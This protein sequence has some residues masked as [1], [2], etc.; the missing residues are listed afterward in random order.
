MADKVRAGKVAEDVLERIRL[1]KRRQYMKLLEV[2]DLTKEL[3]QAAERRD[4][5]AVKMLLNMRQSLLL[6][7][8]ESEEGI[9]EEV[10]SQP[11]EEAIL[12]GTVLNATTAKAQGNL[13]ELEAQ[14]LKNRQLLEKICEVDKQVS[15]KIGGKRSFY[16]S[17]R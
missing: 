4:E 11:E 15:L 1:K 5:V 2:S 10:N 14:V 9:W 12:L 3:A 13:P 7:L 16:N 17:F 6:E 8:S